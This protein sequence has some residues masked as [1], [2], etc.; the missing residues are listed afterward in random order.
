[1][2]VTQVRGPQVLDESIDF[3]LDVNT[4]VALIAS[5]ATLTNAHCV[6]LCDTT[7]AGFTVTLPTAV[8]PSAT[9]K[10]GP[11]RIKN[12]GTN[13]LTLATTSSQTIDGSLTVTLI[14]NQALDIVSN[15]TN[16]NI[17]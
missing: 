7:S 13:V 15:G 12:T 3:A 8:P 6:V 5:G 11:Y 14:P 10:N 16:W 9:V 2:A 4:P 17:L 1:M